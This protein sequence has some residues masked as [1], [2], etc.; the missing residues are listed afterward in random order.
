MDTI[1]I[2]GGSGYI[3]SHTCI[4]LLEENYNVLII[5]SLI[6]SFENSIEKIKRIF[7]EKDK[8]IDN[9][10]QF[11]KGDLRNKN[12]LDQIFI[13]YNKSHKSIKFVIHFAGLKSI[14]SSI[15]TPLEYWNMNITSTLSLL[16]VMKKND[17][18]DLIFSSSATV[19]K[20]ITSRLLKETDVLEPTT[21]YGRTKLCIEKILKDLYDSDRN[22]RIANLRYFNPIG[23]HPSGHLLENPKAM[24]S[25]LFPAIL[26][27]IRGE[28]EKLLVFGKD[29]PTYD[30]TCV[31]DF[32]HVMDLA[33]A[34]LA[35]FHF[36]KK[37]SSK[38]VSINIGTG[39][40]KSILE[41]IKTFQLIND[42]QFDYEFVEKR[43][44]DQP[45]LVADNKLALEL[46]DWE[47]RRNLFDMC[48]DT[49]KNVL[50]S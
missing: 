50:N 24:S 44:G 33:D 14:Y 45:Y 46:L 2:T 41:V 26:K 10:I 38:F 43:L 1:L 49:L 11:L 19:Y 35:T 4:S 48:N 29:W 27:T 21:P 15:K 36:L 31:R 47:P 6:N 8:N 5:D 32:I 17:C 23:S 13:D 34:H 30:G 20:P 25:N 28:Q 22:W 18:F 3:G 9:R 7:H 40:G 12:W 39:R 16:E 42:V 37:N